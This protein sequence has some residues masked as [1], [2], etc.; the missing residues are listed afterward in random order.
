MPEH[1]RPQLVDRMEHIHA[2]AQQEHAD[3]HSNPALHLGASRE[4]ID[5]LMP[6]DEQPQSMGKDREGRTLYSIRIPS[7]AAWPERLSLS[8]AT[9]RA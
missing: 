4:E 8:R 6:P 5:R 1:H 3:N 9:S 7:L 2:F